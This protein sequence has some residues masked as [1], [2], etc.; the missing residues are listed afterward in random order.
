[1]G[2]HYYLA[3]GTIFYP[4]SISYGFLLLPRLVLWLNKCVLASC[5]TCKSSIFMLFL[6]SKT[7]SLGKLIFKI[8][9]QVFSSFSLF[10]FSLGRRPLLHFLISPFF[11]CPQPGTSNIPHGI[12]PR[13][14]L[15]HHRKGLL[16]DLI[17]LN[18]LC[19][20]QWHWVGSRGQ[21]SW[22]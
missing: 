14:C 1:M 19:F 4:T 3:T 13:Q 8:R 5:S 6:L 11:L 20:M 21:G 2:C 7:P 15:G 22:S 16:M 10:G 9:P 17:C 18:H 12:T